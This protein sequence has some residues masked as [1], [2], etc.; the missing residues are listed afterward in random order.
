[1]AAIRAALNHALE[2]G[3]A[4]SDFSWRVPLAAFKNVTK[5]RDIYL[6]RFQRKKLIDATSPDL[7][8]FIRGLSLL[9]LRPGALASLLVLDFDVRL[10]IL[11][12]GRDKSGGDRK[13][14]VPPELAEFFRAAAQDRP[15]NQPLLPRS[16][17]LPWHRDAGK[18]PIK[19][20]VKTQG[21]RRAPLRIRYDTR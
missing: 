13:F 20:A 9:P 16:N 18:N 1:M 12:I 8:Q 7:A 17:G 15:S 6:D 19:A 5:R 3:N 21:Y 10:G 2:A 11:R 4:T 14:K